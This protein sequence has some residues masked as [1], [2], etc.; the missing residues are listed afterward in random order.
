MTSKSSLV[1]TIRRPD[2]GH[3]RLLSGSETARMPPGRHFPGELLNHANS[4]MPGGNHRH[5]PC[6]RLSA[7]RGVSGQSH[8]TARG[9]PGI[10]ASF[11]RQRRAASPV[12]LRSS[13]ARKF[14][15][16]LTLF[17]GR[18]GDPSQLGGAAT[19]QHEPAAGIFARMGK[20]TARRRRQDRPVPDAGSNTPLRSTGPTSG[21]TVDCSEHP[22]PGRWGRASAGARFCTGV[23]RKPARICAWPEPGTISEPCRKSS[24]GG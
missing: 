18:S 12:A 24:C 13:I 7:R 11:A 22:E 19:V 6:R 9:K 5:Q 14:A 17:T 16:K 3:S 2:P 1:T 21:N 15:A 20:T 10:A 23:S 4:G 8:K